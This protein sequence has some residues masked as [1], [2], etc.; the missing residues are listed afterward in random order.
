MR[1]LGVGARGADVHL[2]AAGLVGY[3]GTDAAAGREV[4]DAGVRARRGVRRCVGLRGEAYCN[5]GVWGAAGSTGPRTGSRSV[6]RVGAEAGA[7]PG[8]VGGAA[9][10]LSLRTRYSETCRSTHE[11]AVA[12]TTRVGQSISN[13]KHHAWAVAGAAGGAV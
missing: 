1:G 13:F 8:G 9:S 4:G 6:W 7:A 5:F 10:A 3:Q 2:L 12:G 11:T